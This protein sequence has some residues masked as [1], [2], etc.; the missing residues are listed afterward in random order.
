MHCRRVSRTIRTYPLE[1]A[2][3]MQAITIVTQNGEPNLI[4]ST[5]F[6]TLLSDAIRGNPPQEHLAMAS[7]S[8]HKQSQTNCMPRQQP[9][10][11]WQSLRQSK[12]RCC[13]TSKGL[14]LKR[15]PDQQ[16]EQETFFASLDMDT[17]LNALEHGT[18]GLRAAWMPDCGE[19]Q[20]EIKTNQIIKII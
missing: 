8:D 12:V 9:H 16:P 20:E 2:K 11:M 10:Q 13:S 7:R 17:S 15:P 6:L 19:S 14:E 18:K 4:P 3:R 1:Q 5:T